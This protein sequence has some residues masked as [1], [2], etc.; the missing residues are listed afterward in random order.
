M[1][2]GVFMGLA[3]LEDKIA[4]IMEKYRKSKEIRPYVLR[5]PC[6][7]YGF[8]AIL[9][10]MRDSGDNQCAL[11]IGLYDPC[12]MKLDGDQPKWSICP[13]NT[14]EN[15]KKIAGPLEKI[16]VFP[17]EHRPAKGKWDGWPLEIWMRH[18]EDV[19]IEE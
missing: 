19:A 1:N 15:R 16:R 9:R 13:F 18:I 6:P 14:E 10:F 11:K 8:T 4:G 12:Q 3:W 17:R 7:F 5:P 2:S